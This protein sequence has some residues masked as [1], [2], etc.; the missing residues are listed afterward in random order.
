MHRSPPDRPA[1]PADSITERATARRP[2][3]PRTCHNACLGERAGPRPPVCDP[4]CRAPQQSRPAVPPRLHRP[5]SHPCSAPR[6]QA[7]PHPAPQRAGVGSCGRSD[8]EISTGIPTPPVRPA[9]PKR[10]RARLQS[11]QNKTTSPLHKI[12]F[13][14]GCHPAA[15][16]RQAGRNPMRLCRLWESNCGAGGFACLA[17]GIAAS[18]AGRQYSTQRRKRPEAGAVGPA[19][20]AAPP[21]RKR[22]TAA[23]SALPLPASSSR[24]TMLRTMCFRKPLPLTA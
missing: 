14:A 17:R 4:T 22:R 11:I 3:S 23:P 24:P 5:S 12:K 8:R 9:R 10:C 20:A 19:F 1:D 15:E 21:S 16:V 7:S 13:G 2:P 18:A 6:P